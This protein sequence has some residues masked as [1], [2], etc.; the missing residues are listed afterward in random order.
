[1][2][3]ARATASYRSWPGRLRSPWDQISPWS[4]SR[5]G[6]CWVCA[7]RQRLQVWD[8]HGFLLY[9]CKTSKNTYC[10]FHFDKNYYGKHTLIPL[11]F[12]F[13]CWFQNKRFNKLKWKFCLFFSLLQEGCNLM[14]PR[15]CFAK[16]NW[17][18]TQ[19]EGNAEH[20]EYS[21]AICY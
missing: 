8:L 1:M 12:N 17:W 5:T 4:Q 11:F 15:N 13:F 3:N 16:V 2:V 18:K 14:L 6:I 19:T 10:R 20:P 7:T 21:V 9:L